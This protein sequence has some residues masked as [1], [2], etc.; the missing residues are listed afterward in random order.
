MQNSLYD[1]Y[2]ILANDQEEHRQNVDFNLK[3]IN[4]EMVQKITDFI[5]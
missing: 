1:N 5:G 4:L 2:N 3:P